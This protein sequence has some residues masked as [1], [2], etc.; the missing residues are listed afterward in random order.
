MADECKN[1]FCLY[2]K[3]GCC[4]LDFLTRQILGE[5][6]ICAKYC[7]GCGAEN[8]TGLSSHRTSDDV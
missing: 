6:E 2:W 1:R 7:A 8:H 4:A 5:A 3:D